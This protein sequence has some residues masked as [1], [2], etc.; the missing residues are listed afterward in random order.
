MVCLLAQY[1]P[2]PGPPLCHS[3]R[4]MRW[5]CE[6]EAYCQPPTEPSQT[7]VPDLRA[8]MEGRNAREMFKA[9]KTL[10]LGAPCA[11]VRS[12]IRHAAQ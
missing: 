7:I 2:T 12:A 1:K 6:R 8:R 5:G 9:P 11:L 4:T 10:V 3:V